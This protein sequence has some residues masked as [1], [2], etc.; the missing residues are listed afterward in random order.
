MSLSQPGP[1]VV[2]PRR[3]PTQASFFGRGANPFGN[4]KLFR[5]K[6]TPVVP[7]DNTTSTSRPSLIGN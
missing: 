6:P 1:T 7:Q 3:V 4:S 2:T 5:K